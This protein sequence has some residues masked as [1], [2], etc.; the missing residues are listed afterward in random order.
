MRRPIANTRNGSIAAVFEMIVEVPFGGAGAGQ[1]PELVAMAVAGYAAGSNFIPDG[2]PSDAT[3]VQQGELLNGY[4][5]SATEADV[6]AA[7][8]GRKAVTS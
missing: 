5:F 4:F 6:V 3:E 1:P 2:A 8:E 7:I